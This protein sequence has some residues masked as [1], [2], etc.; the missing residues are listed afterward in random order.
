MQKNTK[1]SNKTSSNIEKTS[2]SFDPRI[3]RSPHDKENPYVM[4]NKNLMCDESLSPLCRFFLMQLLSKTDTWDFRT[5]ALPKDF[6][7]LNEKKIHKF[8]REA[9]EAGYAQRVDILEKGRRIDCIY[10]VA[11]NPIYL[12]NSNN[13]AR[14]SQKRSCVNGSD[15]VKNDTQANKYI[16][17]SSNIE[18]GCHIARPTPKIFT[19]PVSR[20][21][22]EQQKPQKSIS[23]EQ[24]LSLY[25]KFPKNIV[26][27]KIKN[28]EKLKKRDS[29]AYTQK[30][31][32]EDVYKWCL[33]EMS[34][35]SKIF[36]NKK[37]ITGSCKK[38]DEKNQILDIEG[39]RQNE[40]CSYIQKIINDNPEVSHLIRY[41]PHAFRVDFYH[42]NNKNPHS[43]T[44][45]SDGMFKQKTEKW[46]KEIYG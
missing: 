17:G 1:T 3:I 19:T 7:R 22:D 32:K 5:S 14:D 21:R 38:M 20:K 4:I 36:T 39:K 26:D 35:K 13:F 30:E 12:D 27:E 29:N 23:E 44:Y 15:I 34:K 2:K 37:E 31:P 8:W 25:D 10:Y 41:I 24:L 11:E 42:K 33:E 6:P 40:F 9:I 16:K 46:L 45:A 43:G 18:D 28:I